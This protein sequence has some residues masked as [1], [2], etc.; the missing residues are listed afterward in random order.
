MKPERA[1]VPATLTLLALVAACAGSH[2]TAAPSPQDSGVVSEGTSDAS[3]DAA[4]DA[5]RSVP[6]S[7][8]AS[9]DAAE[10][11]DGPIV[12]CSDGGLP[13]CGNPSGLG[14]VEDHI[15]AGPPPPFTGGALPDGRLVTFALMSATIYRQG[16][17]CMLS[18]SD[19]GS[20]GIGSSATL[21]I[22]CGRMGLSLQNV[23]AG[24]AMEPLQCLFDGPFTTGVGDAGA[25]A[26]VEPANGGPQ[27]AYY[28]LSSDGRTL[29][30]SLGTTECLSDASGPD[31]SG[32]PLPGTS[33]TTVLTFFL[34]Q[35]I[36]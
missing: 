36:P 12:G 32:T 20:A 27:T 11:G 18:A 13:T 35:T 25:F 29:T 17:G 6:P 24:G 5:T 8:D 31:A 3:P 1:C 23:L 2:G 9:L 19:S 26:L 34:A 28:S 22:S 4:P 21:E 7:T 14:L 33:S 10:T 15:V 30:V 16:A